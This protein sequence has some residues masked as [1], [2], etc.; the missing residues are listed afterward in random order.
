MKKSILMP[1]ET[2]I[3]GCI[4]TFLIA[5]IKQSQIKQKLCINITQNANFEGI[6]RI[7]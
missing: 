6:L 4:G 1:P 3:L 7:S 2:F 5:I